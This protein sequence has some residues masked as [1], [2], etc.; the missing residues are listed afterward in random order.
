MTPLT[1]LRRLGRPGDLAS[2][3]DLTQARALAVL[4]GRDPDA[5][6]FREGRFLARKP[7]ALASE[8]PSPWSYEVERVTRALDRL[9]VRT[10]EA[11]GR[12]AKK[13]MVNRRF[14]DQKRHAT[15]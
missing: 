13:K 4:E 6:M 10:V 11:L 9:D 7:A 14:R 2:L 5:A 12:R 8:P 1:L 15:A 3:D